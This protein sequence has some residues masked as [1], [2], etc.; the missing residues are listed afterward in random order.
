MPHPYTNLWVVHRSRRFPWH[1]PPL[2]VLSVRVHQWIL[3]ASSLRPTMTTTYLPSRI[4]RFQISLF[5]LRRA[6]CVA[7]Q[8]TCM[9]GPVS[10]D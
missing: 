2:S 9:T 10:I 3:A 1:R 8:S 4:S 7:H 5:F 6:K